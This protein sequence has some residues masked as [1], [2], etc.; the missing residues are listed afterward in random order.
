VALGSILK[1]G[2]PR[3]VTP[4]FGSNRQAPDQLPSNLGSNR[5]AP[6]H[7]PGLTTPQVYIRKEKLVEI[8]N[9]ISLY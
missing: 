7:K 2:N 9:A 6:D 3:P 8:K 1:S 5:K 4:E